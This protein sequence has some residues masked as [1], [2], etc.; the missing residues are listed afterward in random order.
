M[1]KKSLVALSIAAFG[2]NAATVDQTATDHKIITN[3]YLAGAATDGSDTI[4]LGDLVLDPTNSF[5]YAEG[6][7]IQ[8]TVTGASLATNGGGTVA[9]DADTGAT[10]D[11]DTYNAFPVSLGSS[12]IT[13]QVGAT[14]ADNTG[15]NAAVTVSGVVID[16]SSITGDVSLTYKVIRPVAGFDPLT[17]EAVVS[18]KNCSVG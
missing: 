9:V 1:F 15:A 11:T 18:Q 17:I 13:Y 6:D 2:A 5:A 8:V 3:E 12:E 7:L 14:P 10:M 16:A 4:T